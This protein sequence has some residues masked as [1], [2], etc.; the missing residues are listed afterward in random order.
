MGHEGVA[1]GRGVLAF[2]PREGHE[3]VATGR[4]ILSLCSFMISRVTKVLP[5][6][7]AFLAFFWGL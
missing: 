4:R 3:G 5:E 7:A 6:D 1:T 2:V